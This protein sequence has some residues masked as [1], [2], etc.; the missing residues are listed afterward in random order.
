MFKY[1]LINSLIERTQIFKSRYW[2]W[3]CYFF[4]KKVSGKISHPWHT[5]SNVE[6]S[7]ASW[8]WENYPLTA[9]ELRWNW[10]FCTEN[11]VK[12]R[13]A[14]FYDDLLLTI[15][16]WWVDWHSAPHSQ[17]RT[18]PDYKLIKFEIIY[19][20]GEKFFFTPSVFV[21]LDRCSFDT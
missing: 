17:R 1:M 12:I 7:C 4:S 11:P 16:R 13:L 3:Y 5:E 18:R 2:Y 20:K 9:C 15:C 10:K 14:F 19:V 8:N 6:R 21:T